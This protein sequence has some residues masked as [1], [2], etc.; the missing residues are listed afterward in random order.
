MTIPDDVERLALL[1]WYLI[2]CSRTNRKACIKDAVAHA[3]CDLDVIDGW[4]REF[5]LCNWR[6][7]F[8]PSGLWGLDLDRPG[9]MHKADGA[10]AFAEMAQ[11]YP[12]LPLCPTTRSG[13]GG[14][15]LFFAHRGEPIAG[16][17][18]WPAPGIDPRRGAQTVTVPPSI[19]VA[20]GEPYVWVH[21]PW[22]V[23]PPTAPAW[24]LTLVAPPPAPEFYRPSRAPSNANA[25]RILAWAVNTIRAAPPA[26]ANN[27]LNGAAHFVARWVA[28]G[29]VGHDEA[30]GHLLAA[31]CDRRIP[32]Q[33][34]RATI[35]SAFRAGLCKPMERAA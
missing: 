5:G 31:A 23:N 21:A 7:L 3:S 10:A 4:V 26:T 12:P 1:G 9:L 30:A 35:K 27:T 25:A 15:A 18:G 6:V 14:A 17:G 29:V 32:R 19:H 34:A 33:E 28:A 20:T 13:G 24:L 2:P 11:C 16:R 8:G 22:D